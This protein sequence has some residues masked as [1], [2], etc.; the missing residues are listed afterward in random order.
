M[1]EQLEHTPYRVDPL[2]NQVWSTESAETIRKEILNISLPVYFCFFLC[3][4]PTG[5]DII[6]RRLNYSEPEA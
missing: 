2:P 4:R 6:I 1:R 3:S 5:L